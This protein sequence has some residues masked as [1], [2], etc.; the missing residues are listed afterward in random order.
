MKNSLILT[1][2]IIVVLAPR[3]MAQEREERLRQLERHEEQ[4]VKA[5]QTDTL[6][7]SHDEF[8][9]NNKNRDEEVTTTQVKIINRVVIEDGDDETVI[10]IGK[11]GVK[12]DVEVR[13]R[14]RERE[15]LS[16]GTHRSES[17]PAPKR[18]GKQR[19]L[20]FTGHLGGVEVGYNNYTSGQWMESDMPV[21]QWLNLNTGRSLACNIV[22]PPVSVGITRH[23]GLVTALGLNINNYRFDG[24]NS[25]TIDNNGVLTPLYTPLNVEKSKLT[26]VYG[27][28]PVILE[29]QLPVSYSSTLNLGAGV[30]GALRTGAYT[31]MV[32]QQEGKQKEKNHGNY[33]L[34]MLRYGFTARAGYQMI[35][36]YGTWYM[37]PLFEKGKGPELYPFEIGLALTFNN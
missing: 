5:E 24:N 8:V 4:A 16:E 37:T 29:L 21:E 35:Q 12:S 14:E 22:T 10:R 13:E 25:V 27:Y 32:Y 26:T 30:I 23:F 33:G 2:L 11:K 19:R 6:V 9:M 3:L 20:A 36:V 28:I 17:N 18:E 15:R 7:L 34:N 1:A 31:K